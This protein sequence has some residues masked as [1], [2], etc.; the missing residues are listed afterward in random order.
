MYISSK[1]LHFNGNKLSNGNKLK[2][3]IHRKI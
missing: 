3:I 2:E 1:C